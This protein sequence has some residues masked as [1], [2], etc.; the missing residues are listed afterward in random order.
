ML[1]E[2]LASHPRVARVRY[3]GL[4]TD[5]GHAI[6]SRDHAGYGAMIG[7]EIDGDAEDAERVCAAVRLITHATSLGGVESLLERRARHAVDAGFGTPSTLLRL[8]VGIEHVE[9]L[10]SD[11]RQAL[12][13]GR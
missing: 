11:L 6:A 5:P 4:V 7:F 3:P 1:A 13:A 9:D 12:D 10:W 2:R 8:S